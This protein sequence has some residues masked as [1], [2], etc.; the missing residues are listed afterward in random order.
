M[1]SAAAGNVKLTYVMGIVGAGCAVRTLA[2]VRLA[3]AHVAGRVLRR[4]ILVL[5]ASV[6]RSVI[7]CRGFL[8]KISQRC[9]ERARQQ[10]TD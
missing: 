4:R 10:A 8:P 9:Q 2:R 5:R 7:A 6:R 1:T 3:I